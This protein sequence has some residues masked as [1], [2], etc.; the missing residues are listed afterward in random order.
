MWTAVVL[1]FESSPA[2]L[3]SNEDIKGPECSSYC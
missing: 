2:Q 1:L 3:R